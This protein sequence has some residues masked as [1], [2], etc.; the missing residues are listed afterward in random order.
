MLEDRPSPDSGEKD[1]FVNENA[2]FT[3]RRLYSSVI[4]ETTSS[5][6]LGRS[7]MTIFHIISSV[8]AS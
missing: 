3:H 1:I 5:L 8:T 2:I 6:N 7:L 4:R